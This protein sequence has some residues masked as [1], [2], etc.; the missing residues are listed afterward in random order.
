MTTNE[1]SA[2]FEKAYHDLEQKVETRDILNAEIAGLRETVR[3]LSARVKLTE[4]QRKRLWRLLDI[5]DC[6]TPSLADSI[7]AVLTRVYPESMTAADMRNAL[8]ESH[9]GF[10]EFSNPLSACHA[11]L[12]RMLTENEVT[13]E[14]RKDGKT[15]YKRVLRLTPIVSTGEIGSKWGMTPPPKF[16]PIYSSGTPNEAVKADFLK[17][18]LKSLKKK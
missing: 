6:A 10:D 12:K 15:A 4:E 17:D 9:F 8:E 3:V 14:Q 16:E 18:G 13:S 5:I 2:A 11:A 7:R 1:Y